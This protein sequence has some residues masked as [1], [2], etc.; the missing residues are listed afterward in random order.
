M[1]LLKTSVKPQEPPHD[2]LANKGAEIG[3]ERD[4]EEGLEEGRVIKGQEIFY[5]PSRQEWDDHMRT[6]IPF[7]KWCPYCVEGKCVSW[8]HTRIQKSEKELEQEVPVISVDYMGPKP[9]GDRSA[10]IDSLL[11]W[12]ESTEDRK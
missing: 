8:A 4:A 6:H 1:K 2:T 7:R 12:M 3:G 5:Q 10:N 9:K 11:S